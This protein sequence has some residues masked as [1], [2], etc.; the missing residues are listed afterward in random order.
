MK[1]SSGINRSNVA[2]ILSLARQSKGTLLKYALKIL[3]LKLH[4][5][6]NL[7]KNET[8]RS[9]LNKERKKKKHH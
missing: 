1:M 6:K 8:L 4:I 7:I 9:A 5:R 3:I 2:A